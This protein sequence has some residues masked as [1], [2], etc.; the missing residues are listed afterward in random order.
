MDNIDVKAAVTEAFKA[1]DTDEAER[2]RA[3]AMACMFLGQ[4]ANK[5]QLPDDFDA[6]VKQVVELT[7]SDMFEVK[8]CAGVVP[9]SCLARMQLHPGVGLFACACARCCS[10]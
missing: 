6:R 4:G 1:I 2:P 8:V 10:N 9:S 5:S 3:L 7:S